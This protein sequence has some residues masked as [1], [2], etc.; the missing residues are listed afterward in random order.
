MRPLVLVPLL[1]LCGCVSSESIA[2]FRGAHA[3]FVRDAT[4]DALVQ[5]YGTALPE[6]QLHNEPGEFDLLQWTLDATVPLPLSRDDFLVA[7]A[8]AGTRDYDFTGVP[9]LADE[10]LHRYALRL[11]A[12]AF[13]DDDLVVQGYWQPG[14]W[15]DLDGTLHTEDWRLWYGRA[16]AIW[17]A[18]PDVFWKAGFILTD[19]VDTGALPLLGVT[20]HLGAQWRLEVLLPRD[21]KLVWWPDPAWA[22]S[23]GLRIEAD[24]Y[25]IRGPE[26]LG[27]PEHDVHVQEVYAFLG[28]EHLLTDSLSLFVRAGT[29][30]AG[31]YDWSYGGGLPD[32]DNT[33]EPALF[34]TAGLGF[35]F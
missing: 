10:R 25:H 7:G 20:W 22:L 4:S 18:A 23:A 15:S 6:A 26:E 11:G 17:R 14:V 1:L 8:L 2:A 3:D 33:L 9:T 28:A 5:L 32:Y 13:V 34:A 12:G 24:E 16:L 21:L 35:R 31:N 19:A 29:S 30:V 27:T